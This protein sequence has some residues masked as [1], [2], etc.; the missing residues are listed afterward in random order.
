MD[1]TA[2]RHLIELGEDSRTEF[3]SGTNL[4][5]ETLSKAIVALANT[6]GGHLLLGVEDDG[7]VTGVPDP[8]GAMARVTQVCESSIQ[9]PLWVTITKVGLEGAVVLVVEVPAF[10][11]DRPYRDN[12]GYFL[13]DGNRSREASRNELIRLLEST[14]L[15]YDETPIEDATLDDLDRHRFY[16]FAEV[17]YGDHLVAALRT[18]EALFTRYLTALQCLTRA[19]VPTVAGLLA[20]GIQPQRWLQ[21]ARVTC[22]RIDGLEPRLDFVDKRECEGDLFDQI[23]AAHGFLRRHLPSPSAVTSTLRVERGIPDSVVREVLLNAL[24]HRDYRATSQVK[25][26]VYNDR[27]EV[28]N[29]GGLLNQLDLDSIRIGGISQTRNPA[30][31][32]LLRRAFRR[33]H[34]GFGL[35][36]VDRAM[37][38]RGLPKPEISLQAGHFRITLRWGATVSG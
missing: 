7:R 33:E 35:P 29:A 17:A 22:A 15:H 6:K 14:D 4:P 37:A 36:E 11:P 34:L 12:R 21:D 28:V 30:V 8:N 32:G 19:R 26:L 31:A 1:D 23:D 10:G 3:K 2:L 13:R 27:V 24:T 18:D 25:V 38:E 16:R 9:P 20:F 5:P